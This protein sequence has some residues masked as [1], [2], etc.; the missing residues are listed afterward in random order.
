MEV[1]IIN[2]AT[3]NAFKFINVCLTC[4]RPIYISTDFHKGSSNKRQVQQ[5]ILNIIIVPIG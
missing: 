2:N 5:L 3:L 4:K 1:P